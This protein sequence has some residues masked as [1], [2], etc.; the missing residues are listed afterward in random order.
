M[1]LF[2][3]TEEQWRNVNSVYIFRGNERSEKLQL[4]NQTAA[5]KMKLLIEDDKLEKICGEVEIGWR[6]TGK[7]YARF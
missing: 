5:S 1:E 2:G 3:K 6:I 7:L 4:F